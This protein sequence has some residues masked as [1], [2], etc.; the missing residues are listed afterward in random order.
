ML[1]EDDYQKIQLSNLQ[2]HQRSSTHRQN[3]DQFLG[4]AGSSS[5]HVAPPHSLFKELFVEFKKGVTPTCGFDLPSGR[6]VREKAN[7]MLW[8]L[9]EANAD[10]KRAHLRDADTINIL[11]DER[12]SRM[13]IRF[14][15]VGSGPETHA[16]YLGQAR[17]NDPSAI[18]I[19]AATVGVF[20]D[21][22]TVRANPPNNAKMVIPFF[23]QP[24]FEHATEAVEA[25]SIDSA[26]NEV[27]SANDMC[28]A[29]NGEAA[30]FPNC[31]H[32]LRDAAHSSRRILSRLFK[33]DE[34]LAFV[35]KFFHMIASVIQWSD[36]LRCL[37]KE[38][39][40]ESTDAAVTT[41]FQ[42]LRAAKHRIETM[43]T[44]L[45]RCCLDPTGL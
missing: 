27:V 16:G 8:C 41:Q 5:Y 37:Y 38:C 10:I 15:C 3:V 24:L 45:S 17:G 33:A 2:Y 36:D 21:V 43:L 28:T 40:S 6:V 9:N 42:H 18:G 19:T 13:H 34:T 11:R 23:D 25:I 32:P 12:H 7:D 44:P 29:R 22:C 35:F 14:R 39:T 4:I 20:K 30:P 31:R 26:E 1:G